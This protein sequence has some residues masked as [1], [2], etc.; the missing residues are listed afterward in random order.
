[1]C[2]FLVEASAGEDEKW[3]D[4]ILVKNGKRP[5]RR[6]KLVREVNFVLLWEADEEIRTMGLV[7]KLN[8]LFE[9]FRIVV[10]LN[11]SLSFPFSLCMYI[12]HNY[13]RGVRCGIDDILPWLCFE[14]EQLLS[15]MDVSHNWLQVM[16]AELIF[17]FGWLSF[18][19]HSQNANLWSLGQPCTKL[20]L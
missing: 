13:F 14:F 4:W 3:I 5:K 18:G 16:R 20:K 17:Y 12:F 9:K 10:Q 7:E 2:S 15:S 19:F 1:M 8:H 6:T 11:G